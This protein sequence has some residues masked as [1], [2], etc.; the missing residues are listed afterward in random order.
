M[1]AEGDSEPRALSEE[2]SPV[3]GSPTRQAELLRTAKGI[4]GQFSH[5]VG[6][7]HECVSDFKV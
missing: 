1:S 7:M 6:K 3:E 2:A 4:P 5:S